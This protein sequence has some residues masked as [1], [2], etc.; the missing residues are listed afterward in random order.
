[1]EILSN[2]E[3][4]IFWEEFNKFEDERLVTFGHGLAEPIWDLS[5]VMYRT[6]LL[7]ALLLL[8]KTWDQWSVDYLISHRKK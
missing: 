6:M 8:P 4:S 7:I 2:S 5:H 1:M 3:M